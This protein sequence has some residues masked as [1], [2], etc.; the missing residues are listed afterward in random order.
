MPAKNCQGSRTAPLLRGLGWKQASAARRLVIWPALLVIAVCGAFAAQTVVLVGAGSSVPLPLYHRWA[1]EYNRRDPAI[2]MQYMPMGTSEGIKQIARGVS[3]FGAGEVPLTDEERASS[4]L[5]ELPVV[6]IGIVPI[7]NLPGVHSEVRFSGELLAEIYLGR[8]KNWNDPAIAKLNPDVSL[9]N[10]PIKVVYRPGGKGTN[11]VFSEFLSKTSPRFREEVGRSPSPKWPIGEPAER[12]SDMADRVKAEAGA[13]G[14]VELQYAAKGNLQ[15]GSV[16]NATG[17][18]IKAS[19]KSV[20]AAC[21][22]VE[23]GAWDKFAPS[24][25]NAPG[26]ESYP[27]TSFTW[28]YVS[29]KVKDPQR[30]AALLDLLKWA[31]ADGQ[32]IALQEGYSELPEQLLPRVKARAAALR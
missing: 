19:G 12:S 11:Y 6:L 30:T 31:Y 32:R 29:S 26:A 5:V 13:I 7:Y 14:Y 8:V 23:G 9:P 18:F 24:L 3:D 15:Y 25:T 27:I 4:S 22:A 17:H 28:I 16:L 1:E 2:Q 10:M 21:A 20:I